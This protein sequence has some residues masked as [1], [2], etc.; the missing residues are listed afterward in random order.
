MEF[1]QIASQAN[2]PFGRKLVNY[3]NGYFDYYN[4][5]TIFLDGIL[6]DLMVENVMTIYV[7]V[8]GEI[9]SDLYRT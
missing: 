6:M 3:G 4:G 8:M 9:S 7:S 1:C 5:Q 2:G